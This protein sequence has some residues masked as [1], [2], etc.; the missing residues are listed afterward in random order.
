MVFK[1]CIPSMIHTRMGHGPYFRKKNDWDRISPHNRVNK[2]SFFLDSPD[3]FSL[4][5]PIYPVLLSTVISYTVSIVSPLTVNLVRGSSFY[6]YYQTSFLREGRRTFSENSLWSSQSHTVTGDYVP[7]LHWRKMNFPGDA[8]RAPGESLIREFEFSLRARA[9]PR[10][11]AVIIH[12]RL[13]DL[14]DA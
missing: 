8:A 10:K 3:Q 6:A 13:R 9:W 2:T 1:R 5:T 11:G 7:R 4:I 12:Q 14:P